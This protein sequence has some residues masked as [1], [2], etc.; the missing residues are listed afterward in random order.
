V[1]NTKP[2][3]FK[4]WYEALVIVLVWVLLAVIIVGAVVGILW[5]LL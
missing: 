5:Y 1:T 4:N 3:L 2:G